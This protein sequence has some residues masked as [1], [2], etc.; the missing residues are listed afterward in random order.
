MSYSNF[1]AKWTHSVHLP[2]RPNPPRIVGSYRTRQDGKDDDD[3]HALRHVDILSRY[4]PVDESR[5]HHAQERHEKGDS[6]GWRGFWTLGHMPS[7]E[8]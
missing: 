7:P 1:G 5:V 4:S 8:P 3:P 6:C 2:N